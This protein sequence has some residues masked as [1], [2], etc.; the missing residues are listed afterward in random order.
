V[1]RRYSGATDVVGKT[2]VVNG[3]PFTIVG[4]GPRAVRG[5]RAALARC[6]GPLSAQ[7][8]LRGRDALNDRNELAAGAWAAAAGASRG[9]AEQE[10]SVVAA[11]LSAVVSGA[12]SRPARHHRARRR[13]SR[14]SASSRRHRAGDGDDRPGADHCAARISP[15]CRSPRAAAMRAQVASGLR[16]LR[17]VGGFVRYQIAEA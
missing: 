4:V 10:V 16:W 12:R 11:R 2:V 13:S 7:P 6:L 1:G 14:S 3:R 15:T 9:S 17:G 5:H 8:V